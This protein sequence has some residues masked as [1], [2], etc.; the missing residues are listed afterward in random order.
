MAVAQQEIEQ[1]RALAQQGKT[2]AAVALLSQVIQRDAS[3]VA[4]WL[5]LSDVVD[6]PERAEYCLQKVLNLDPGNAAAL[7]KLSE[8]KGGSL[9]LGSVG[10]LNHSDSPSGDYPAPAAQGEAPQAAEIDRPEP[11]PEFPQ[12]FSV[13]PERQDELPAPENLANASGMDTAEPEESQEDMALHEAAATVPEILTEAS[14][15]D[16]LD[17]EGSQDS[18]AQHE[19]AAPAPEILA[20]A[21]NA[22]AVETEESPHSE[23]QYEAAAGASDEPA[24]VPV[25]RSS[26][27]RTDLI[28]I[29]LT[30][31]AGIVLCAL[32]SATLIGG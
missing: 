2:E 21:S 20:E 5:E 32:V 8:T 7:E 19:A 11:V 27:G 1:A 26:V 10:G 23:A 4:A 6:D 30:V 29:G 25:G 3:N 24:Q 18:E 12:G 9:S 15:A 16:A 17:P 13:E 22:D 28:L 14:N 31:L